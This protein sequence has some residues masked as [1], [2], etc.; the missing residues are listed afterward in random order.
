MESRGRAFI[1][2]PKMPGREL[3]K[4][5]DASKGAHRQANS[6]ASQDGDF[7]EHRVELAITGTKLVAHGLGRQPRGWDIH[8]LEVPSA[9]HNVHPWV[10]KGSVNEKTLVVETACDAA[11]TCVIRVW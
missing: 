8:S 11:S 3:Q 6:T 7:R 4:L 10:Q 5:A 1:P 2:L 9:S